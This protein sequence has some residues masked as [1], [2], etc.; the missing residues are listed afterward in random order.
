MEQDSAHLSP[1]ERVAGA[2]QHGIERAEGV[3]PVWGSDDCVLWVADILEEALGKDP[4]DSFRR[5]YG[6]QEQAYKLIGPRGL[7]FGI[8][9]RA[10]RFGWKP[11]RKTEIPLA[12]VG[13]IG[14]YRD[15][16]RGVQACV[17]KISP[18]FWIGRSIKGV[19][20]V[21]N[22]RIVAAWSIA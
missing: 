5:K 20:Y 7:A 12:Q 16:A 22:E 14:V 13:D 15:Y 3:M 2:I 4:A 19:S 18:R 10:R 21:P 8:H 17:L 6:T 9:R 1:R 11:I